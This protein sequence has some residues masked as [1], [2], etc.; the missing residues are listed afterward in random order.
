MTS[1][2]QLTPYRCTC[3][4]ATAVREASAPQVSV[5]LP[6]RNA[7]KT[8]PIALRSVL[9]SRNVAFE[10]VAVDHASTDGTRAVFER[11]G[12]PVVDAPATVDV[13]GA[14]AIGLPAC[15]APYVAR[16]DADDVMHPDRLHDD[17]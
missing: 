6:A 2:K 16:F 10:I 12:V 4:G 13:G 3:R 1:W 8:L 7:A 9:R 5:L 14:L 15:R 17:V 11:F